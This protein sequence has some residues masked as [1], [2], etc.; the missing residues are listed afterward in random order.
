MER[1]LKSFKFWKGNVVADT[2]FKREEAA[3]KQRLKRLFAHA[4]KICS[5]PNSNQ[6]QT[7]SDHIIN[8]EEDSDNND[9]VVVEEKQK[10]ED[11]CVAEGGGDCSGPQDTKLEESEKADDKKKQKYMEGAIWCC[12][13][14]IPISPDP[15]LP[16]PPYRLRPNPQWMITHMIR[17]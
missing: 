6:G 7:E 13:D 1:K 4:L 2:V 17:E 10:A 16:Q 14:I 3:K 11:D 5:S 15:N 12:Y 9:E 8:I